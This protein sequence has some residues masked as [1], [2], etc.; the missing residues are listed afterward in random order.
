LPDGTLDYADKVLAS[1]EYVVASVHSKFKMS[2]SEMTKRIT[3]ALRNK[4]V[5]MLGHPTGRLLLS[6]EAY[7]INMIEVIDV[8]AD[9][10]KIIEINAHPLRL[11]LDWRLCKYA[12]EKGVLIAINPDAH[13][14]DGLKDVYYGVGVARKGWLEKKNVLNAWTLS[15]LG[16][17]LRLN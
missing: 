17:R 15:E 12:K 8:A 7:P 14:T 2:E 4:Y 5:T 10:G 13:N 1:L 6:R 16:E 3:K 9:N 11:D